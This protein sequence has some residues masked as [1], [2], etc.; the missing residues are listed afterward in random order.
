MPTTPSSS[1]AVTPGSSLGAAVL[2]KDAALVFS[3]VFLAALLGILTRPSAYLAA[4]WPANAVL[5]GLMVREAR[6]ARLH[7][8]ASAIG[9]YLAADFLTGGKP[10]PTLA[11]TAANL[12]GVVA[13]VWLYAR[14]VPGSRRLQRPLAILHLYCVTVVVA[15]AAGLPGG[16]AS[17]HFFGSSFS[18]GFVLWVSAEWVNALLVLP[19]VISAPTLP[20]RRWAAVARAELRQLEWERAAPLLALLAAQAAGMWV[21]GPG[22]VAFPVA[23][24]LWCALTY[25]VFTT[26][27]ISF[28]SCTVQFAGAAAGFFDV[29]LEPVHAHSLVSIRLG[30]ALLSLG[31]LAVAV[32][33]ASRA[34]ALARL[35]RAVSHDHLTGVLARG[36]FLSHAGRLLNRL[37]GEGQGV[38]VLMLDVDHF[39]LVN[40]RHGHAS[41]DAV[42]AGFAA[43]A[44]SA[45]R[46]ED[47]VGRLGGEEFAAV[48]PRTSLDDA[49]HVADRLRARVAEEDFEV[50]HGGTLNVTVSI[51]LV[52]VDDA[53]GMSIETLLARA[54]EALYR[55]KAQGR[56]AVVRAVV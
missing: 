20:W 8:W 12:C 30:I 25:T 36:A 14:V 48:L 41:G 28:V 11:L 29:P 37:A 27:L 40:D 24:L 47:L 56:N 32:S 3:A 49:M 19:V 34:E 15:L 22:G 50:A 5:L 26:A 31:P 35:D 23:A 16:L 53:A 33:N 52:R 2:R 18:S 55:A 9:G 45:L 6:L 43:L 44:T 17:A 39:K 13:G 1:A 38:A 7:G 4:F 51:G 21:G 42:L 46:P 54:D 10:L